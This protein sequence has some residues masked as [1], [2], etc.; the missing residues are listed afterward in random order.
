MLNHHKFYIPVMGTAFTIDTPLRVAKYGISSVVSIGDDMLIED[1]RRYHCEKNDLE[2]IPIKKTEEDFRAKRITAYLNLLN[3]LVQKQFKKLT[4]TDSDISTIETYLNKYTSMLPKKNQLR[5]SFKEI[6]NRENKKKSD[7]QG[8]IERLQLGSIDV[9]IM[10]KLDRDNFIGNEKLPIEYNDAH[11][12]LRGFANS[13]LESSIIFS[14]GMNPRLYSYIEK[15]EDFYPNKLG[16]FKKKVV[17][18]V[19]DYRSALIQGKFLAKKG[20][21]VSEY[22]IESGLNC[23]GHAF[24]T[25]GYLMGPILEEFKSKRK[26]LHN[27]IMSIL[28]PALEQK[29]K[30]VPSVEPEFRITAQ[31]GVGTNEE[32]EFLLNYYEI[33]AV[34]WGTPF[35]LVPEATTVDDETLKLLVKAKEE[36]LYLSTVSPLGVPFNYLRTNT[37]DIE[38]FELVKQGK[39]GSV[40]PKKYLES[41]TE[42]TE[43][44][45]CTASRKYQTNKIKELETKNLPEPEFRRQFNKIID[46]ACLCVGLGNAATIKNEAQKRIKDFGV[47]I[48]PGPNLAYFSKI[49]SLEELSKHIYGKINVITV[50][51][52]PNMYIKELS[53][54]IDY[55]KN[56]LNEAVLDGISLDE[57]YFKRFIENL[58]SGISYYESLFNSFSNFFSSELKTIE[59]Q[60]KK[61]KETI[62]QIE[63]NVLEYIEQ[64]SP[65]TA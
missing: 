3:E 39:P 38:K 52:R 12:G 2:Y 57:K 1:M 63:T 51:N 4:S 13:T 43:K 32:Q 46:K 36:D 24:A 25:D 31:G 5:E 8:L 19:S 54:Y 30:L 62:K 65:A 14:A 60:L 34:G 53:L 18:K 29:G 56:K 58:N 45:I 40:C 22:R 7:Y 11:A 15:F 21:W 41:N 17:L 20:I 6:Y 50:Q 59:I 42:F 35:L 9:N 16:K 44:T 37:K 49:M 47:S 28:L 10:T 26:E 64:L 48:C 33:D 23:G 55:I 27:E 61:A